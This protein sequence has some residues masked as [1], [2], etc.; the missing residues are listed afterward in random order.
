MDVT[1]AQAVAATVLAGVGGV[2]LKHYLY[3]R[4]RHHDDAATVKVAEISELGRLR[5]ELW[6]EIEA[7]RERLD[8]MQSELDTS[9]RA[10][11]DL[12]GEHVDLKARH[13]QLERE[14]AV[15]QGKYEIVKH[16]LDALRDQRL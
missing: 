15:L 9:R 3:R 4:G 14:H 7:L 2:F 8:G 6:E 11:V 10:Y 16:E 12:L 5:K 1:F 13:N